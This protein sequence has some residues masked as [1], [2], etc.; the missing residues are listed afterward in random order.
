V[1]SESLR[2]D[3]SPFLDIDERHVADNYRKYEGRSPTSCR[4]SWVGAT[5]IFVF[6]YWWKVL[7]RLRWEIRTK[8]NRIGQVIIYLHTRIYTYLYK[9][10]GINAC[11]PLARRRIRR[12]NGKG[13]LH[14]VVRG[15]ASS[16]RKLISI[17]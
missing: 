14:R 10:T 2:R 11:P 17:N 3:C 6:N 5:R 12:G 16:F 4:D 15:Y 1:L 13:V 9:F 8:E 7:K